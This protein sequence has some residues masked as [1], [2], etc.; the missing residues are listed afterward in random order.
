MPRYRVMI[1]RTVMSVA[2]VL[3]DA[4]NE[5]EAREQAEDM[6]GNITDWEDQDD[7]TEIVS[8]EEETEG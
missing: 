1:E 8:I 3:I 2:E 4:P 6:I 7:E 5:E